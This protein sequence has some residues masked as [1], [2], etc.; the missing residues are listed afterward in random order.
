MSRVA[1]VYWT[2]SGNT[3]AMANAVAEGA[4]TEAIEV[5]DFSASQVAD[6]DAF[7]FGCPAMGSEELDPDFE[8]VWNDCVPVFGDKPVALFG[9]YDWGG[10]EWMN[11]WSDA[12]REA[13]VNVA[14]TLTQ[15]L[16]VDDEGLVACKALGE[17]LA[18]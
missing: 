4:G 3:E 15:H 2:M 11:I 9:S 12:A 14:D 5:S 8:A 7:A 6:Y 18:R 13:G 17:K 16:E 10:G 1:V